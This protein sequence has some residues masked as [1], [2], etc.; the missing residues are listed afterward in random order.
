MRGCLFVTSATRRSIMQLL[1]ILLSTIMSTV[2]V[3]TL[4]DEFIAIWIKESISFE[5]SRST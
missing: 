1:Y 5:Y 3:G 2:V 4:T